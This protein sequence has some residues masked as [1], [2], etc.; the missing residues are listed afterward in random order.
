MILNLPAIRV[1]IGRRF[2][3]SDHFALTSRPPVEWLQVGRITGT[4][5]DDQGQ[6]YLKIELLEPVEVRTDAG[7]QAAFQYFDMQPDCV[8]IKRLPDCD[9]NE[10]CRLMPDGSIHPIR[11]DQLQ[12]LLTE[13]AGW[14]SD[15]DQECD[16]SIADVDVSMDPGQVLIAD[17]LKHVMNLIPALCGDQGLELTYIENL[18]RHAVMVNGDKDECVESLQA[19]LQSYN[20]IIQL[21]EGG[22]WR[23]RARVSRD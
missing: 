21:R 17:M 5:L 3:T 7:Q 16:H 6:E 8:Y 10:L 2:E 12:Q 22:P 23:P 19:I 15:E 13:Q 14:E 11:P 18:D 1:E 9:H 20:R 4:E